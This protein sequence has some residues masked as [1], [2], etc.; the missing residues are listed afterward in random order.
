[1]DW[2]V[3]HLV[4]D[5]LTHYWY[6]VQCKAFGFVRN[7]KHEGIVCSAIIRASTI[8]DTN[9]LICMEEDKAYVGSVNN[10]PK[11]WTI[12]S[13]DSECAQCDCPIAREGMM[14]KHTIK[15]FKILHPNIEDGVI[16]KEDGTLHGVHRA[17]PMAQCFF[18]L[19]QVQRRD[20]HCTQP[21]SAINVNEKPEFVD[22]EAATIGDIG[23]YDNVIFKESQ[24][25]IE[26]VSRNSLCDV[27][28]PIDISQDEP[29]GSQ[30]AAQTTIHN[31]FTSLAR[32][33]KTYPELHPYLLAD[34]KHIRGKQTEFIARGVATLLATPTTSSFPERGG[35]NSLKRHRGFIESFYPN[36]KKT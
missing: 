30:V 21:A 20:Q 35:D 5:V 11:V 14:C 31:V 4:G 16:V 2:L 22:L 12:H 33:A 28:N 17:T 23:E 26:M 27:S 7:K 10:N 34:L 18:V 8:P 13:P 24:D 1:M 36:K 3:Y 25:S 9:V 15:V 32:T 29:R 6:G 19:S